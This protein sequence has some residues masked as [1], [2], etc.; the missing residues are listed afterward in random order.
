MADLNGVSDRLVIG[1]FC[2]SETLASMDFSKKTF[3]L[4]DCE[5]YEKYLFNKNNI[6]NLS[7]CDLLIETHDFM[8]M[9]ISINVI[10]LFKNTHR[11]TVIRSIDDIDKARTYQYTALAEQN[12]NV[13]REILSEGRPGLMEWVYLESI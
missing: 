6:T 9:T 13:R 11:C 4:C 10:E 2:S 7:K 12:L 5:G 1:D 3:I 8:D